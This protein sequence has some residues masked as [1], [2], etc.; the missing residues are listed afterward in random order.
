MAVTEEEVEKIGDVFR[1]AVKK[2]KKQ[3]SIA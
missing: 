3:Y 1:V 2:W